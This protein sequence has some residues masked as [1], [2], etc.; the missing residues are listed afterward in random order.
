MTKREK[1]GN[2]LKRRIVKA[3]L[4]KERNKI[5]QEAYKR[6][7]DEALHNVKVMMDELGIDECSF[8][9]SGEN[10]TTFG[11]SPSV[12]S[13]KIITP[14]KIA[15]DAKALVGRL[16]KEVGNRIVSKEYVVKDMD[17]LVELLKWC[18]VK[19]KQFKKF[20]EVRYSV[21]EKALDNIYQTGVVTLEDLRGCY[22]VKYGNKYFKITSKKLSGSGKD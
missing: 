10:S 20:I 1:N 18:G 2:E 6:D 15:Y 5:A 22:S 11:G 4:I 8:E 12:I 19:P 14:K 16:G 9:E 21:D 13:C 17:G 7:I 3:F